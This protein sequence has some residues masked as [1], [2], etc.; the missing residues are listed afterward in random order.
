MCQRKKWYHLQVIMD[1]EDFQNFITFST[2]QNMLEIDTVKNL[3]SFCILDIV[4]VASF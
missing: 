4:S 2:F 1:T 3:G